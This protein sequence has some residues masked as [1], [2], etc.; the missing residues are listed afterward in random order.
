M[1]MGVFQLYR[2]LR[3][4]IPVPSLPLFIQFSQALTSQLNPD[5]LDEVYLRTDY[6]RR[7]GNLLTL[8]TIH[9]TPKN[10]T[11][12]DEFLTYIQTSYGLTLLKNE[13]SSAVTLL[14]FDNELKIRLHDNHDTALDFVLNNLEERTWAIIDFDKTGL[15]PLND[16]LIEVRSNY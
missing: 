15:I 9:I 6:V 2:I 7:W 16:E 14:E 8:G 5:Q 3:S 1:L 11:I 10:N 13:T 4:P 12:V